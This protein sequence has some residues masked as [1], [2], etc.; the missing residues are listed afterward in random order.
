MQRDAVC[1]ATKRDGTTCT[2]T[3]VLASGRCFAHDTERQA[4]MSAARTAGGHGKRRTA[5]AE[6]LVPST[7]RPVLTTLLDVLTEVRAGDLAPGQANA[8]ATVAGA[9]VKVYAS[10][11]VE[12]QI[13]D[14]QEQVARL[15]RRPA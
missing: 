4:E 12:Q 14:L 6:K 15:S 10:A 1:G 8:V 3:I 2:S 11:T 5:R 9:I 7:L 13:A